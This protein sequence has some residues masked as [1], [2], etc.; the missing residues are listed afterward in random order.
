MLK[1]VKRLRLVGK[2]GR[3][4]QPPTL[5][6]IAFPH[7]INL[8]KFTLEEQPPKTNLDLVVE[9]VAGM[10]RAKKSQVRDGVKGMRQERKYEAL[11]EAVKKGRLNLDAEGFYSVPRGGADYNAKNLGPE[12]GHRSGTDGE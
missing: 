3:G 10:G 12:V 9:Y 11:V 2:P 7:L 8:G 4:A 1:G 6:L 5:N